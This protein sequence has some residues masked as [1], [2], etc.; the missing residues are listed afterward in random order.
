M[1]CIVHGIPVIYV[2][3]FPVHIWRHERTVVEYMPSEYQ[4]LRLTMDPVY[5]DW[6]S[7]SELP[8]LI[9]QSQAIGNQHLTMNERCARKIAAKRPQRMDLE[10]INFH[11]CLTL[12]QMQTH[13]LEVP[14]TW[15]WDI[16]GSLPPHHSTVF[17]ADLLLNLFFHACVRCAINKTSPRSPF[18]V[19]LTPTLSPAMSQ[20]LS[21][22]ELAGVADH[23]YVLSFSHLYWSLPENSVIQNGG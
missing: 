6:Y 1:S 17:D 14:T 22:Q 21:Y 10:K 2:L 9:R 4:H 20:E 5:Y 23:L 16:L 13:T 11:S 19:S 8:D 15:S 7:R 3:M 18:T 12:G